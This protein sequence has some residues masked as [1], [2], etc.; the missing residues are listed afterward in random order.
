MQVVEARRRQRASSSLRTIAVT[1]ESALFDQLEDVARDS[2]LSRSA[3][4][5]QLLRTALESRTVAG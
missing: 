4:V 3:V 5:S 1:I 2:G